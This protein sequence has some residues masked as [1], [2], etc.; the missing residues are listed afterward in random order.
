MSDPCAKADQIEEQG[1]MLVEQGVV[2]HQQGAKLDQ[3][4]HN[5]EVLATDLKQ[6]LDRLTSIIEED[7]GT[8]KD[9]EQLKKDREILFVSHRKDADR[10]EAIEIRNAK[11]DGLGVFEKFPKLWDFFQVHARSEKDFNKVWEWYIMEQGI[12]RFLPAVGTVVCTAAVIYTTW[13]Q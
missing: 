1:K 8:R 4:L 6:A 13:V 5:Q 11:C 9:V 3:M 12:R 7:I 10:I 2:L